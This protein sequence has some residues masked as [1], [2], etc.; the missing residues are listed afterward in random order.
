MLKGS[1]HSKETK[2]KISNTKKGTL[3]WNKGKPYSEEVRKKIS[4]GHKGQIPWNKGKTNVYSEQTKKRISKSLFGRKLSEEVRQNMRGRKGRLNPAWKGGITPLTILIRNSLETKLWR[5]SVF[6][7]DNFTCQK[8]GIRKSGELIAH[9]I[10]NFSDFPELRFAIDNGIT[11]SE[12]AHKE[13]H[14]RYGI[15]NNTKKQIDDFIIKIT[16]KIKT[17]L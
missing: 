1:H 6:E 17:L 16:D 12:K 7:R 11:L 13:F 9:H 4:E 8:Y 5:K 14:K 3:A 10:N 2:R 15:K